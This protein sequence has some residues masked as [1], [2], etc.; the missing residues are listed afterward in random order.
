[1]CDP[2]E[3]HP[4]QTPHWCISITGQYLASG[5]LLS[6]T[7]WV[8]RE[9]GKEACQGLLQTVFLRKS[10]FLFTHRCIPQKGADLQSFISASSL[11]L[12]AWRA[13]CCK[14]LLLALDPW[15][16]GV[17]ERYITKWKMASWAL[18]IHV[19]TL[20]KCYLTLVQITAASFLKDNLPAQFEWQVTQRTSLK[21]SYGCS[22][23][24]YPPYMVLQ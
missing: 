19:S 11:W 22:R 18:H 1:M 24:G 23:V 2:A 12:L 15:H 8:S 17:C 3:Y 4:G 14:H 20:L 10:T 13:S 7:R 21:S 16:T 9:T 5:F 6:S